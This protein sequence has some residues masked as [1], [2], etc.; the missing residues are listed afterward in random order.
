MISPVLTSLKIYENNRESW[1]EPLQTA[2][3]THQAQN[4]KHSNSS[5]TSECYSKLDVV[6][7]GFS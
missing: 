5:T 6:F 3:L 1:V 2:I 7:S 4:L